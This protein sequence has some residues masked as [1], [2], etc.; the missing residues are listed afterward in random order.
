MDA[1]TGKWPLTGLI[2]DISDM[3]LIYSCRWGYTGQ[4][5]SRLSMTASHHVSPCISLAGFK[6]GAQISGVKQ[7]LDRIAGTS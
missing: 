3:R 5:Y 1:G 7:M 2:V 4:D 6:R